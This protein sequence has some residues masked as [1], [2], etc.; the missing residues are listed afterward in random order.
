MDVDNQPL[1]GDSLWRNLQAV[2]MRGG[3]YAVIAEA[4]LVIRN[5]QIAW[6]G[7]EAELP[8]VEVDET[9][10]FGGHWL[11]PGLVDCHTHLVFGGD[12]IREFEQ[13]LEGI[14]YSEIARQGGGIASSVRETRKAD[15]DTLLASAKARARLLLREGVTTLEIKSGYGLEVAKTADVSADDIV[16]HDAH[17]Q[18][19]AYAFALSR[20]SEQNLDHMVM[21]IFRQVSMPTYDDAA[22]QQLVT[23]RE[24]RA[25]DMEA[26]QTLLRGK[27]T[28]TVD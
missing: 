28:W 1:A 15:F 8:S 2:T 10:D 23:A 27:D 4:A 13:R 22:R 19:P 5:G 11:T 24:S 25:H 16:T 18:D 12:R 21:G 14:S 17:L 20:L 26:L 9:R 3:G 6:I 7:P